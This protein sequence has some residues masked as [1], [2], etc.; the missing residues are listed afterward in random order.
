M[1]REELRTT[2]KEWFLGFFWRAANNTLLGGG[3]G[4]RMLRNVLEGHGHGRFVRYKL[5]NGR[6]ARDLEL[7]AL[8]RYLLF[9]TGVKLGFSH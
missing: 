9:S 8:D 4:K 5:S 2:D 1:L 6:R 3:G 7:G